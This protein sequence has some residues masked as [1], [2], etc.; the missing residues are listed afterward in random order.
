MPE[1]AIRSRPYSTA[2]CCERCVFGRGEHAEWCQSKA[3]AAYLD[4]AFTEAL[5]QF[6]EIL[7]PVSSSPGN[8][9][10]FAPGE[11]IPIMVNPGESL[12]SAARRRG[13][14]K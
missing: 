13:L 4:G 1:P 9:R 7:R 6:D 5:R 3:I 12:R 11:L 8:T 2:S 10:E 14:I